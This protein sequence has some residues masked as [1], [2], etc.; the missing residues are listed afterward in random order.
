MIGTPSTKGKAARGN[1]EEGNMSNQRSNSGV[2]TAMAAWLPLRR[3][4]GLL[5]LL[6]LL[7]LVALAGSATPAA[8]AA[9]GAT[10]YND[11]YLYTKETGGFA[12]ANPGW[13]VNGT[14]FTM[15]IWL[16]SDYSSV[17]RCWWGQVGDD[18]GTRDAWQQSKGGTGRGR[19]GRRCKS[20]T[21][22]RASHSGAA[23]AGR[24]GCHCFFCCLFLFICIATG[25]A[26]GNER[27]DAPLHSQ[28]QLRQ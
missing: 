5:V 20:A 27:M 16:S 3:A 28:Q 21:S 17:T 6:P 11:G 7:L 19:A 24:C 1:H 15:E 9:C 12:I 14:S 8:G 23:V 2:E 13:A 4:G 22:G 25:R 10:T 26:H 18:T